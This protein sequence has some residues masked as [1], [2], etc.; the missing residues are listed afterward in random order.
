MRSQ[1]VIVPPSL[2]LCVHLGKEEE[3]NTED[4]NI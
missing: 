2:T 4:Y 3:E 1:S